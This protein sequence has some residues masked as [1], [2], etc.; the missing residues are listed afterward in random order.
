MS[1]YFGGFLSKCGC[2]ILVCLN[3]VLSKRVNVKQELKGN[4]TKQVEMKRD[5]TETKQ[6]KAE[7]KPNQ[8]KKIINKF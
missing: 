6:G 1:G 3:L 2:L 7:T 5:T 8:T 4:E